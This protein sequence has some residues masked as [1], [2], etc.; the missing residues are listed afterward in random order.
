MQTLKLL[1]EALKAND[2][3]KVFLYA[4]R[5]ISQWAEDL[6]QGDGVIPKFAA[7]GHSDNLSEEQIIARLE[8]FA[9]AKDTDA[10]PWATLI[11]LLISLLKG[12][13]SR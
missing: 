10:L 6:F 7:E 5:I 13:F 11:P 12:L 3:G 1:I 4:S 8:G 9:T 2:Y